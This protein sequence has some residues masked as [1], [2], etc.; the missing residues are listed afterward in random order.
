[1]TAIEYVPG[2]VAILCKEIG[3]EF[4][5]RLERD[6]VLLAFVALLV[7][8][9]AQRR[10]E[11]QLMTD[12][13]GGKKPTDQSGRMLDLAA[14]M[15]E[16]ACRQEAIAAA[17]AVHDLGHELGLS[18]QYP[19]DHLSDMVM[20]CASAVRF[21]F[22]SPCHSRH[23]AAAAG[24][25][26][27]K[28]YACDRL[29]NHTMRWAKDWAKAKFIEAL[30][31]FLPAQPVAVVGA[32]TGQ[33]PTRDQIASDIIANIAVDQAGRVTGFYDAADAVLVRLRDAAAQSSNRPDPEPETNV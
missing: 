23:A 8:S 17:T 11:T 20:S 28:I 3:F 30:I 12:L 4:D 6:D 32:P 18:E 25:V 9:I 33:L 2:P 7:D 21:G 15:F 10:R 27:E 29:D 22:E 19:C 24:H 14:K 31:S 16:G 5:H 13:F 1:M 26:W